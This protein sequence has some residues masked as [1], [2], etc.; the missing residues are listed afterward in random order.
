VQ[1]S[2]AAPVQVVQ[3][4]TLAIVAKSLHAVQHAARSAATAMSHVAV[5]VAPAALAPVAK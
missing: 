4:A 1:S 2:T 5:H 3:D